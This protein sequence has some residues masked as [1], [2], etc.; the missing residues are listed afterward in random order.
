MFQDLDGMATDLIGA[1]IQGYV[2]A[3]GDLVAIA[4]HG[5]GRVDGTGIATALT[6]ALPDLLSRLLSL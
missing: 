3:A 1:V 2:E 6:T 5:A 4:C